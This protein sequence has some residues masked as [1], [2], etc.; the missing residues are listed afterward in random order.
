MPPVPRLGPALSLTCKAQ[1]PRCPNVA[2]FLA[3]HV[4]TLR[5]LSIAHLDFR[6]TEVISSLRF[7]ALR[8]LHLPAVTLTSECFES[9]VAFI[10]AHADQL[11]DV[12]LCPSLFMRLAL[13]RA[14]LIDLQLRWDLALSPKDILSAIGALRPPVALALSDVSAHFP[15]IE[16]LRACF[17]V[18]S[19]LR[20]PV[21]MFD[22]ETRAAFAQCTRLTSFT[23]LDLQRG[24]LAVAGETSPLQEAHPVPIDQ[25]AELPRLRI[26]TL[27]IDRHANAA[28]MSLPP[29]E[30]RSV[31]ITIR[32]CDVPFIMRLMECSPLLRHL[33]LT[34]TTSS[35]FTKSSLVSMLDDIHARQQLESVEIQFFTAAAAKVYPQA[36][37]RR[38]P[39]LKVTV[40]Q[41]TDPELSA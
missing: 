12:A 14:R 4:N 22:P 40:T 3:L 25:I 31:L 37:R 29:T 30:L 36:S 38:F 41:S 23:Q 34:I 28:Q 24:L 11:E 27:S 21:R 18:L 9:L 13:P 16:I 32:A 6:S 1:L 17:P 2:S 15:V 20:A 8:T 33:H 26:A 5:E 39:W 35:K 10:G 19:K 7:P